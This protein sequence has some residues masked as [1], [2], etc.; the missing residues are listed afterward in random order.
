MKLV[1]DRASRYAKMRAHTATHLLHAELAKFFPSTKQAWSL[2]DNDFLRF[3]FIADR[4]LTPT[5]ITSIEKNINQII[6]EAYPV[7]TTETSFDEASKLGAKAFFEDKYGERV[8]VVQVK[9][10]N[11]NISV[12]LC[13]GTHIE[14]TKDMW[15]FA[16]ISQ[17]AVASWVK[18]ISAVTWPKVFERIQEVQS[19]L[20]Q[21]VEKLG[22]K[23]ASQLTDK[24]EKTLKEYD[25]M[26]SKLES[27]EAQ[28]IIHELQNFQ[29]PKHEVFD[30]VINIS[31]NSILKNLDF[32]N[33]VYHTK[34]IFAKQDAIVYTWEGSYAI[35]TTKADSSAKIIAQDF[36]L[37]WWGSET[38]FQWRDMKVLELFK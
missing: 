6:F 8:R 16:I 31:W 22:I 18:R 7:Q 27:M 37:K 14:N 28:I 24:L 9:N 11:E 34:S 15:C 3:D 29:S 25:E 13:G 1:V 5:E 26:K 20:D 12:E 35:I 36:W 32:K 33:I 2:V 23:T 10:D 30:T 38:L 21:T 17:E 19:I 4:L